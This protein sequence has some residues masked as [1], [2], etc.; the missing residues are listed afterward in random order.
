MKTWRIAINCP[1]VPGH[2]NPSLTLGAELKRRGHDV[3]LTTFIDADSEARAAGIPLH[4]VAELQ[5]PRGTVPET[6]RKLGTLSGFAAS[7]FTIK[8]VQ[9]NNLTYL[10]ELPRVWESE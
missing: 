9:E 7:R 6:M 2:L 4:P 5:Y 8:V 1:E 3:R 10:R